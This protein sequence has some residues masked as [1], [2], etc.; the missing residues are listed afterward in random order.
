MAPR[1]WI[2]VLVSLV[3]LPQCSSGSNESEPSKT[4]QPAS[5]GR[6][7][8]ISEPIAGADADTDPLT[9]P[10]VIDALRAS[11][12]PGTEC[13]SLPAERTVA[14]GTDSGRSGEISVVWLSDE[15]SGVFPD[16]RRG[17]ESREQVTIPY[18]FDRFLYGTDPV[19][20]RTSGIFQC[21]DDDDP[22]SITIRST[23]SRDELIS[24]T[25][26]FIHNLPCH[27]PGITAPTGCLGLEDDPTS[28]DPRDGNPNL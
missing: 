25:A 8:S 7:S 17:L 11:L 16:P 27:S 21:F 6:P 12:P 15:P 10:D 20:L 19:S 9:F 2:A 24:F 23:M 3:A 5:S 18:S 4:K 28:C 1:K 22:Q 13:C 26:L 14:W